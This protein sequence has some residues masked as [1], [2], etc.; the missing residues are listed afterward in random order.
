MRTDEFD[1]T[2]P[3]ELIAQTPLPRGESR[4][5]VL[6][7]ADGRIEHRA[8]GDLLAYLRP[9]DTLVVN[10]TRVTARRVMALRPSG[11]P[12]ELL[13]VRPCGVLEWEA[14]VRPGRRLRPGSRL[15]VPV[16]DGEAVEVIVVETTPEGGRILRFSNSFDAERVLHQGSTP[17]PPYIH[18]ALPDEERY[19]TVYAGPGG[20]A[21]APTAGL[22]FTQEMLDAI[23]QAGVEIAR[24]T[25]HI[26][27]D[28]FRPVRSGTIEE[29]KMHGEWFS[30][31]PESAVQ[32]NATAGRVV[33]VGTTVVRALETA[34][35]DKGYVQAMHSETRLFITPGFHFRIVQA[36]LTNFH[37]PRSTL[38]M[39]V[40]AFAGR[41]KVLAAY[42]AAIAERYR[43]YSFG[44]AM[45]II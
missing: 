33:A 29:H 9:G 21:A 28:T 13:L 14:L 35:N 42:R 30:I 22:H 37:L 20:S 3:E 7:R 32:I 43:F 1:Y 15:S 6:H 31:S 11:Q 26:G 40:S 45:L 27:V 5:L 2:L 41:E 18:A 4:L 23:A 17:L 25:L 36:L 10:D 39:L 44:D 12:A 24:I 8:F 16:G 34:A 38:L 19:Q